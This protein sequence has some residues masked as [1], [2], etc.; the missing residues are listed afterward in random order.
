[1]PLYPPRSENVKKREQLAQK[2]YELNHALR[3]NFTGQKLSKAIEKY[4]SA[5]L[6]FLKS[7]IHLHKEQDYQGRPGNLKVKNLEMEITAWE[8]FSEWEIIS[9]LKNTPE[10]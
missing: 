7:K 10:L 6:S 9:K 4:R 1:M 2:E 8:K 5:M 3:N